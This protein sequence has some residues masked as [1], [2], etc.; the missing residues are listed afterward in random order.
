[1]C[2]RLVQFQVTYG[3]HTLGSRE[4]LSDIS[5]GITEA[6]TSAIFNTELPFSS[7][8]EVYVI[9]SKTLHQ[10]RG[11]EKN[12]VLAIID[13]LS[14]PCASSHISFQFLEQHQKLL[15]TVCNWDRGDPPE[16]L[17]LFAPE[18]PPSGLLIAVSYIWPPKGRQSS[19]QLW[20]WTPIHILATSFAWFIISPWVH[21]YQYNKRGRKNAYNTSYYLSGTD[22]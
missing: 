10:K 16:K 19:D 20:P 22:R 8:V 7:K 5:C 11:N 2:F 6:L 12:S 1:M 3:R 15:S 13:S 9:Q 4:R 14:H 21:F 18:A 17:H